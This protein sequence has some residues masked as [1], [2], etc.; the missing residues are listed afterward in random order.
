[1]L[2][3]CLAIL[4]K[5]LINQ[6]QYLIKNVKIQHLVLMTLRFLFDIKMA[7][8]FKSCFKAFLAI[9]YQWLIL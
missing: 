2:A 6:T 7:I 5:V 9:N 1:M 4:K 8:S 3:I